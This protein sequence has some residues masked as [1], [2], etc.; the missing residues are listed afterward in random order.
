V[1]LFVAHRKLLGVDPPAKVTA[2]I[3]AG[4]GL[5]PG[6]AFDSRKDALPLARRMLAYC[7]MTPAFQTR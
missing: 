1:A 3:L 5:H 7:A 4:L 6:A 2:A